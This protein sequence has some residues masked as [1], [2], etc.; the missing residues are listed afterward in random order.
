MYDFREVKRVRDRDKFRGCL[1]G[2]AAGDALGYAV[3]FMN[4]RAI[5]QKYGP[6][7]IRSY[8]LRN[9]VGQISDDTQMTLFTATGLLLGITRLETRGIM[10]DY[11]DYIAYAYQGWYRTQTERYPLEGMG[12]PGA[13]QS[14][15]MNLPEM[16]SPRAPG[17][18]CMSAIRDGCRGTMENPLNDSKGCGGVM[19]VA[20]I[21][22]YFCERPGYPIEE[23]DLL[24]ARAAALTHGNAMGWVPAAMLA[25]IVRL[26][27]E[28]DADI[29]SAVTNAL[30]AMQRIFPKEVTTRD[31]LWDFNALI[32]RALELAHNGETDLDNIRALGE[33]W[34]GDEAL[35]IA[36]Y[37]AVRYKDDFEKCLIAAVNHSGDSDSTGAIAGNILGASLGYEALP[38]KFKRD[39]ELHDVI[40]EVADD[41][42]HD[43]RFEKYDPDRVRVWMRKYES[44]EYGAEKRT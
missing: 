35:A 12:E 11:A 13:F 20:P 41:L 7:G 42:C 16:F 5:F 32:R 9:G 38:E 44:R 27:A 10:G 43:C 25:H 37:C 8:D 14:W 17:N 31:W 36:V 4:D 28:L 1:I 3:E 18:T 2:G 34:V 30:N 39:L 26:V 23:S 21:G 19:R 15:L 24:A 22:L 33:G 6:G 29:E 40:L